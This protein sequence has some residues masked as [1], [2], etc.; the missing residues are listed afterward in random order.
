MKTCSL[1]RSCQASAVAFALILQASPA[2]AQ[3]EDQAAARSLFDSGRQLAKAGRYAAACPKFDAASKL[4]PSAGI[5]LNLADCYEKIGKTASAWTE[6]GEAASVAT[7]THREDDANEAKRRQAALEAV[8]TLLLIRVAH[9]SP[10]LAVQRDGSSIPR[11]VWGTAIPV[12]P[13][14]Y[15]VRAQAAGYEPWVA[16]IH[17]STPGQ[18]VTVDIPELRPSATGEPAPAARQTPMPAP[19]PAGSKV[20]VGGASSNAAGWTLVV[21]GAAV[22]IGAGALMIIESDRSRNPPDSTTYESAQ[23]MWTVGVVGAIAGGVSVVGGAC[24]LAFAHGDAPSTGVRVTPWV[25]SGSG[26]VRLT[27][28]W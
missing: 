26:G 8:L 18:T 5:L 22:G 14:S 13:G 20:V 10:G 27:G 24:L 6:F 9:E 17:A 7:R 23:T 15:E 25:G 2:G 28:T 19:P 21:I 1:Y 16:P 12:D 4:Y 11:A 3:A